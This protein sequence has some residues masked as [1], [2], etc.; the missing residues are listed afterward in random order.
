MPVRMDAEKT[1]L[2]RRSVIMRHTT[3]PAPIQVLFAPDQK[4]LLA[5]CPPLAVCHWKI[6]GKSQDEIM[7]HVRPFL[8]HVYGKCIYIISLKAP[9]HYSASIWYHEISICLWEKPK[10]L[11]S[12]I[13]GFLNP[14]PSPKTNYFMFGDTRTPKRNP[15]KAPNIC[16]RH[17][18]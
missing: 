5:V 9:G 2:H 10:L 11:T 6:I 3:Q 16:K 1:V 15:G 8:G 7:E 14:P 17:K 18:L 4:A 13:S 12:R